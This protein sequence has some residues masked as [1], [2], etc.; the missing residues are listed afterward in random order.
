MAR[1]EAKIIVSNDVNLRSQENES[2]NNELKRITQN[3]L[4]EFF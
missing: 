1:E 2:L 4:T 3:K